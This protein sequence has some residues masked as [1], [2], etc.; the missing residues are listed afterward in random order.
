MYENDKNKLESNLEGERGES[1]GDLYNKDYQLLEDIPL[2]NEKKEG[3]YVNIKN[4]NLLLSY[5]AIALIASIMGGFLS[6]SLEPMFRPERGSLTENIVSGININTN[7]DINTVS[8]VAK[9]SM[10]SVVGITTLETQQFFFEE[11]FKEGVGSG[12]IVDSNGYILTNSHVVGNGNAKEIK[13]LL[14]NGDQVPANLLWNDELLD[15]AIIKVDIEG[16]PVAKLGDSD[17]LQ[18]GEIAVAIGNPLGLQFQSTVTSGVI[19]G[20]NRSVVIDNTTVIDQL[21]QTDASINPG[22]SGGPLLNSRGEVIGINT[23]KINAVEGMG[24]AIPINRTKNIVEQVIEHGT[25]ETVTLGISGIDVLE[26]QSR[27]GINLEINKGVIVLDVVEDSPVARAGMKRGD[28]I[29]GMDDEDI[30]NFDRLRKNLYN[31]RRGDS[32]D[33]RLIRDGEEIN[34]KLI[35]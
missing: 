14:Y 6:L 23:A 16:L 15:L 9:K 25:Y 35:F 13:V 7:D 11:R 28:I 32:S 1:S 8:A 10:D 3:K 22:N 34:L 24:F 17:N 29:V 12:V 21:I 27:L 5:F 18:I 26:Y 19:S 2:K 31:Y 4:R 30:D 33:I 20:L